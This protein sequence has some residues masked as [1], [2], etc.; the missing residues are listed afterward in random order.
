M[1]SILIKKLHIDS[2][3]NLTN[4]EMFRIPSYNDINISEIKHDLFVLKSRLSKEKGWERR[5]TI[6]K[7]F[8]P[9][10]KRSISTKFGYSKK[11]SPVTIAW[12]K[13]YEIATEFTLF[14]NSPDSTIHYFDNAAFPGAF[15]FASYDFVKSHTVLQ[16]KEFIWKAS[17]ALRLKYQP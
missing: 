5:M 8:S 7:P 17:S 1:T 3:D 12:L 13:Q 2:N 14:D 6:M 4:T 10:Y 15:I 9:T 16:K 11:K